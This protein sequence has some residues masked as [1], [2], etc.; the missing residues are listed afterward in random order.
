V[1]QALSL[2]LCQRQPVAGLIMQTD[3]GSQYGADSYRQPLRQHGIEPSRSRKGN[4]WD[5]AV[6]ESFFHTLK[7]ALISLDE[8]DTYA[9][10][11]TAV[12]DY[13]EVFS[14]RQRCHS[15]HGDLAPLTY[16]QVVT[17][18]ESLCPEKC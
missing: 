18:N 13:I 8:D 15:A 6:A 14:N 7:T 17:T 5:T 9:Q 1:N 3:R 4:W 11:Q 16:E 2:A 12:F 10:A